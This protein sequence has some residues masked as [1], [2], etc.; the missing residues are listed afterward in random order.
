MAAVVVVTTMVQML[1]LLVVVV[2]KA[3]AVLSVSGVLLLQVKRH[4]PGSCAMRQ[5]HLL[6]CL[7]PGLFV[8]LVLVLML[9]LVMV[10]CVFS[11]RQLVALQVSQPRLVGE[12]GERGVVVSVLAGHEAQVGEQVAAQ[13]LVLAVGVVVLGE[14]ALVR[15]LYVLVLQRLG[16]EGVGAHG[17]QAAQ[18]A[19][20]SGEG[21]RTD[22]AGVVL[23]GR[24]T[25]GGVV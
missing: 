5:L 8:V 25:R 11:P 1:L 12:V 2:A 19:Q 23:P 3:V 20:R 9:V 17:P 7:M 15:D 13:A 6:G 14:E 21:A 4:T 18:A 24:R 22:L 10:L 16:Q